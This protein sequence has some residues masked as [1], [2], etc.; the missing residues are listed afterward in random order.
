MIILRYMWLLKIMMWY[1]LRRPQGPRGIDWPQPR[2]VS[3]DTPSTTA[4][5]S[6]PAISNV[7]TWDYQQV[8]DHF[9][10]EISPGTWQALC[11]PPLPKH[12]PG[13]PEKHQLGYLTIIH[14]VQISRKSVAA[15][16]AMFHA[17]QSIC[18]AEC[19]LGF[20]LL[21]VFKVYM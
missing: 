21:W 17:K 5:F 12:C 2:P 7:G 18:P 14:S 13:A 10:L 4:Q 11:L 8:L 6:L 1:W 19:L 20:W 16:Q 3:R 9:L 15:Y